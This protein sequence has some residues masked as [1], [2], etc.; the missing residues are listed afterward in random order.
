MINLYALATARVGDIV[1][2]PPNATLLA[3]VVTKDDGYVTVRPLRGDELME[4]RGSML[5]EIVK[6]R[7]DD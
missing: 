3:T 7:G 5:V 4:L 2:L 1:R 6:R